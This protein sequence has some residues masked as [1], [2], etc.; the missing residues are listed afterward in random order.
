MPLTTAPGVGL[1]P[2]PTEAM[3]SIRCGKDDSFDNCVDEM[4]EMPSFSKATSDNGESWVPAGILRRRNGA[5]GERAANDSSFFPSHWPFASRKVHFPRSSS[6]VTA[7]YTRPRTHVID[8]PTLYYSPEDVRRFKRDYRRSL[9]AQG[10]ARELRSGN[11]GHQAG[12][13]QKHHD[14]SFWRSKVGGRWYGSSPESSSGA[15]HDVNSAHVERA[16]EQSGQ[17]ENSWDPLNDD[18][19][20]SAYPY[21]DDSSDDSDDDITDSTLPSSTPSKFPA[22][23][24][25]S[26]FDVAREAVSIL[27]GPSSQYYC[28]NDQ[29]STSVMP[30]TT[31]SP[32]RVGAS[33]NIVKRQCKTSLHYVDTLYLF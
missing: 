6:I 21:S 14:N 8:V 7:T 22:S 19:S 26:V 29:Q 4:H 2:N 10:I 1:N 18:S 3:A 28:Q 25:S 31:S 13:H 5:I 9:R 17:D 23:I 24:F 16:A 15:K 20:V 33:S 12:E 11:N 27:N 32:C 30:S